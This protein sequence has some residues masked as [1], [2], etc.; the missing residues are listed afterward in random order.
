[1]ALGEGGPFGATAR[2]LESRLWGVSA[3]VAVVICPA[4][5]RGR[6]GL[7]VIFAKRCWI[8]GGGVDVCLLKWSWIEI[9]PFIWQQ[10]VLVQCLELHGCVFLVLWR[11]VTLV[12]KVVRGGGVNDGRLLRR[13]VEALTV[14]V[15]QEGQQPRSK[16]TGNTSSNQVDGGECS[17]VLVLIKARCRENDRYFIAVSALSAVPHT[18]GAALSS[19]HPTPHLH[20]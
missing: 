3:V 13:L 19:T 6:V 7:V 12:V 18:G 5:R 17:T 11:G 1:M 2:G 14:H 20:A 15:D 10:V 9:G 4:W 16:E 8:V